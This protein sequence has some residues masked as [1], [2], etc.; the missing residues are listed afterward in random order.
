MLSVILFVLELF[1]LEL[2]I[3]LQKIQGSRGDFIPVPISHMHYLLLV[4]VQFTTA[5]FQIATR[6]SNHS[7]QLLQIVMTIVND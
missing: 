2:F 6:L 5:A 4:F 3:V 1:W 7:P